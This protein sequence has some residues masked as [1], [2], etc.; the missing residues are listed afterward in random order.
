MNKPKIEIKGYEVATNCDGDV[1]RELASERLRE[2]SERVAAIAAERTA[3]NR[4]KH[5]LARWLQRAL[6][7]P[8][9]REQ[10]AN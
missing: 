7:T 1:A 3:L 4:E 10:G 5:V 9:A 2:I 6:K 8:G